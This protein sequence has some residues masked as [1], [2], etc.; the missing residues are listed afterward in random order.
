[1]TRD[2]EKWKKYPQAYIHYDPAL[3][4][5]RGSQIDI[6]AETKNQIMSNFV[7]EL[8]L[9]AEQHIAVDLGTDEANQEMTEEIMRFLTGTSKDDSLSEQLKVSDSDIFHLEQGMAAEIENRIQAALNNNAAVSVDYSS[10]FDVRYDQ[11]NEAV[12]ETA[13]T[14]EA[15]EKFFKE[16]DSRGDEFIKVYQDQLAQDVKRYLAT[17]SGKVSNEEVIS[18]LSSGTVNSELRRSMI[19]D[20]LGG[21]KNSMFR[22]K[23]GKYNNTADTALYRAYALLQAFGDG[24]GSSDELLDNV[25]KSLKKRLDLALGEFYVLSADAGSVVPVS[26][27]NKMNQ[28]M[29]KQG[30]QVNKINITVNETGT[31]AMSGHRS[32]ND[33]IDQGMMEFLGYTENDMFFQEKKRTKSRK[34]MEVS[35]EVQGNHGTSY[36]TFD[37]GTS[38]K[39]GRKF[40]SG[41]DNRVDVN[42]GGFQ[43]TT[44]LFKALQNQLQLDTNSFVSLYNLLS[45]KANPDSQA[46]GKNAYLKDG[47]TPHGNKWTP[48]YAEAAERDWEDI[49]E[50]MSFMLLGDYISGLN[51]DQ[52]QES[53]F[54]NLGGSTI[55]VARLFSL[56][57]SPS[58][59]DSFTASLNKQLDDANVASFAQGNTYETPSPRDPLRG[60]DRSSTYHGNIRRRLITTK[61]SVGAV[62][63]GLVG[64]L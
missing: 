16:A 6:L 36:I 59:Y 15:L 42:L 18:A 1:M 58:N 34:N 20:I 33:K 49:K 64:L 7:E 61:F 2:M 11:L 51:F 48:A 14:M 22:I 57:A 44:N 32:G 50:K 3:A 21:A 40:V 9:R 46:V 62:V 30:N 10:E 25:G 5:A 24:E 12:D 23:G 63:N 53:L 27:I 28:L 52:G 19:S 39:K 4:Y 31:G 37:M 35:I 60:M 13:N 55:P 47:I 54:L 41:A 29:M 8:R 38:V 45:V 43:S 56:L 17:S 26:V